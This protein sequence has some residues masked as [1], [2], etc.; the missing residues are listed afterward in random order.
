MYCAKF[1]EKPVE[2]N[3]SHLEISI[4]F[5]LKQYSS[6][7]A[8]AIQREHKNCKKKTKMIPALSV[9]F[10]FLIERSYA[11]KSNDAKNR[12]ILSLLAGS[13]AWMGSRNRELILLASFAGSRYP[14]T[15]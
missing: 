2:W 10:L 8:D 3:C 13:L 7:L 9:L 1:K 6:T 12:A 11:R 5:S 14:N 4:L 15:D